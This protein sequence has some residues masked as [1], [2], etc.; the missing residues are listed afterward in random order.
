MRVTTEGLPPELIKLLGDT[1]DLPEHDE[2][3]VD[4]CKNHGCP[5]LVKYDS[6]EHEGKDGV[7][8]NCNNLLIWVPA[9]KLEFNRDDKEF[10]MCLGEAKGRG[11]I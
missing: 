6:I 1:I 4:T 5:A 10:E 9:D 3:N 11:L 7:M 8:F 2:H